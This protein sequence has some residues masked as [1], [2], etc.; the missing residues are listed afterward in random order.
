MANNIMR[1]LYCKQVDAFFFKRLK[2]NKALTPLL[3]AKFLSK[4]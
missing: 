4:N 3:T 1:F 2:Q